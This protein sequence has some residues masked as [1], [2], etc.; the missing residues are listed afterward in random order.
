MKDK[1]YGFVSGVLLDGV[2]LGT[3]Q[4]VGQGINNLMKKALTPKEKNTDE[5]ETEEKETNANKFRK[6]LKGDLE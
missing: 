3:A 6:I 5:P 4:V 1:I 2:K